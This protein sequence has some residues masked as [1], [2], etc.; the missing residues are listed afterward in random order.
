MIEAMQNAKA[1]FE[2]AGLKGKRLALA[3]DKVYRRYTGFSA[4]ETAELELTAEELGEYFGIAVQRVLP[5][6]E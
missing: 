5:C 1:L 4:L 2:L 6:R 3:L